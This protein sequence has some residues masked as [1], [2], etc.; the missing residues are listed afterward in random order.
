MMA[1]GGTAMTTTLDK[2]KAEGWPDALIGRD[3]WDALP[4]SEL[5]R[6]ECVEGVV[7][8]VPRPEPR[9]Q[10]AMVELCTQLKPQLPEGWLPVADSDVVLFDEPLTVRIPDVVVAPRSVLAPRHR[11]VA[12]EVVLA[13]E[14]I[15]PGS[16]RIDR[17]LKLSEYQD[18]GIGD[19]WL[20]DLDEPSLTAFRLTDGSY[21]EVGRYR[22]VAELDLCG[23]RVRIDVPGL[24]A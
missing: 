8:V 9:H 24:I 4:E 11:I 7:Q 2:L 10:W 3:Q 16:S 19:Y 20:V 18:A 13:V 23:T 1:A 21:Q 12:P 5:L 14:I 15:S 17:V 6:F 22:G